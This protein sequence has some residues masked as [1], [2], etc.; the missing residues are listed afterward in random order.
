M[1]EIKKEYNELLKMVD[2][3]ENTEK[4]QNDDT[5]FKN[6]D[7]KV[8]SL[9]GIENEYEHGIRFQLDD[10]EI[11]MV[12]ELKEKLKRINQSKGNANKDNKQNEI[13]EKMAKLLKVENTPGIEGTNQYD[14]MYG[15]TDEETKE[16]EELRGEFNSLNQKGNVQEELKTEEQV[17]KEAEAIRIKIAKILYGDNVVIK[18]EVLEESKN[19]KIAEFNKKLEN[20]DIGKIDEHEIGFQLDDNEIDEIQELKAKL[21]DNTIEKEDIL[22]IKTRMFEI[23]SNKKISDK[24]LKAQKTKEEKTNEEKTAKT[25][26]EKTAK[27]NEE[28]TAK[29]N[30]EQQEKV[31]KEEKKPGFFRRMFNK[32]KNYF[33]EKKG[34]K[35]ENLL[36][37]GNGEFE[38]IEEEEINKQ[39]QEQEQEP[40]VKKQERNIKNVEKVEIDYDL[41]L[42]DKEQQKSNSQKQNKERGG[43]QK[44]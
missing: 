4:K 39:E 43:E 14:A 23:L 21:K 2:D 17:K 15:L 3:I 25:N 30:E 16:F 18:E 13:R 33:K 8:V 42:K 9:E 38:I 22:K 19:A 11:D 40:K 20:M 36:G 31:N 7:K 10:N 1:K 6:T 37:D 5:I 35:S 27:T 24:T 41:A 32:I 34:K 29:T 26:E 28:K 12:Q 44:E